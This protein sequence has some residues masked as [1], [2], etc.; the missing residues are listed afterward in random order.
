MKIESYSFGHI[1]VA[2]NSYSRDLILLPDRVLENWWRSSGHDLQPDDLG[3]VT[4]GGIDVLIIGTGAHGAMR[5]GARVREWMDRSGI[6]WE[7]HPTEEACRR[8]NRLREEGKRAA[9]ALHLTC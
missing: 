1:T 9:A 7:A 4:G 6:P 2:G 8:Y 3:A 5:V